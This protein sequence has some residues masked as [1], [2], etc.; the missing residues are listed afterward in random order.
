MIIDTN[1][2]FPKFDAKT[3]YSKSKDGRFIIT[4]TTIEVVDIKSVNYHKKILEND[5]DTSDDV[6][7]NEV[8]L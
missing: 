4:K 3:S 2:K 1:G 7:I 8:A 6:E 5:D